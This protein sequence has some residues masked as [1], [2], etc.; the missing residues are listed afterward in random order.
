VKPVYGEAGSG[1]HVHMMLRKDGQNIFYDP[2]GYSMLSQTA[3][4]YIGG[5]LKHSPAIL[6]FTN[7]STN[8]YKRLVPGFEAPVSICFGTSN[9]SSVIRIPGYASSPEKK[10][11]EF[12]PSD[13]SGNP[14]LSYSVLLLAGIDGIINRIDPIK[15]GFG[16]FDVNVYELPEEERGKIKALPKSLDE[17]LDALKADYEF[18]LRG[19]V[20]DKSFIDN[21]I[22]YKYNNEYIPSSIVPTPF[23]FGLYYDL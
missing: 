20:F 10:R 1:M 14:Y 17:A 8:S 13:A 5:I 2:M 9:R 23:E 18:L 4:Y 22:D 12:R 7:P 19:G 16:P 3:M 6:A 11:F 15:E 21:W